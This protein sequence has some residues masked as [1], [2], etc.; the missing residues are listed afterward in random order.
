MVRISIASAALALIVAGCNQQEQ[1]RQAPPAPPPPAVTVA[2][3]VTR[4]VTD[5]EEYVGRFAATDTVEMRARVSGYL[6]TIDFRDGQVVEKGR[7]LFTI[8]KRPY[9]AALDQA[10]ADLDRAKARQE[11]AAADLT[12]SEKLLRDR[13][14][15]EQVY[16]QRVAAKK[17]ADAQ[18]EAAEAGLRRAKLEYDFTELRAP[19]SGRIGDRKVASGNLVTGGTQGNTTLL[20]TIVS[21]DPI[22]IEF[23]MDEAAYLRLVRMQRDKRP[24]DGLPVELKLLDESNFGHK[25]VISFVDNV[26]D[27]SSGTIRMRATVANPRDL[28]TPGMFAQVRI[29]ASE[30][31][32]ALLVPET[33]ILSDQSR[34]MVMVVGPQNVVAPRPVVLGSA[35]DVM[36]V[37]RSGLAMGDTIIVNGLMRARPGQKVTPQPEGPA[38]GASATANPAQPRS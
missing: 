22:N 13:N 21:T 38:P 37:V 31:Y 3:P 29:E 25:S 33:A 23:T 1:A 20:A 7:L 28:F 16:D 11:S 8:D 4:T 35:I 6:A 9:E 15:S 27:Q 26:L 12:R 18:L 19:V 14:V 24:A 2:S 32:E 10:K 34:K 30:P 5:R 36:R 17:D